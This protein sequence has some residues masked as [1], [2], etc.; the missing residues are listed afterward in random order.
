MFGTHVYAGNRPASCLALSI[1]FPLAPA[2]SRQGAGGERSGDSRSDWSGGYPIPTT[3]RSATRA[4]RKGG[5]RGDIHGY[6]LFFQVTVT[7]DEAQL[8]GR[9]QHLPAQGGQT[10]IAVFGFACTPGF[11]L[12][13]NLP[14]SRPLRFLTFVLLLLCPTPSWESEQAAG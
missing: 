6:D 4:T 3:S 7:L 8:S 13:A 5:G 14:L 2:R 12:P 10:G 1:F 11:A 9:G